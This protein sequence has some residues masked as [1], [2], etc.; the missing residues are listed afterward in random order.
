M[1]LLAVSTICATIFSVAQTAHNDFYQKTLMYVEGKMSRHSAAITLETA[2]YGPQL[3]E[4]LQEMLAQYIQE[5]RKEVSSDSLSVRLQR[6][7]DGLKW[8]GY[9]QLFPGTTQLDEIPTGDW[10]PV[11]EAK[12]KERGEYGLLKE[13]LSWHRDRGYVMAF[14]AFRLRDALLKQK[15]LTDYMKPALFLLFI[16]IFSGAAYG[17]YRYRQ[18]PTEDDTQ[19]F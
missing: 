4:L 15:F 18:R 2:L 9:R 19:Y 13:L 3:E 5:A 17:F 6:M 14:F 8:I 12:L 1:K 11:F 16:A 10:M 7:T